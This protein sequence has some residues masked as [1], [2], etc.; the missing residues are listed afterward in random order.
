[1]SERDASYVACGGVLALQIVAP[2]AWSALLSCRPLSCPH[3][4][5]VRVD[6]CQS[7]CPS[8]CFPV[9]PN[10]CEQCSVAQ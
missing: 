8:V 5:C 3:G 4:L 10:T 7:V 2:F 1:M 6:A 9:L